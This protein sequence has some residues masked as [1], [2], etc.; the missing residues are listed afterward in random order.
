MILKGDL[1]VIRAVG[2]DLPPARWDFAGGINAVPDVGPELI[3][4]LRRGTGRRFPRSRSPRQDA[5]IDWST[6]G[7]S[8]QGC[9]FE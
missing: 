6:R 4:G 9:F 1:R 8:S 5:W 3:E 2:L 7:S